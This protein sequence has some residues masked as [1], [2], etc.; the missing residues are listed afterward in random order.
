LTGRSLTDLVALTSTGRVLRVKFHTVSDKAK[1]TPLTALF[2]TSDPLLTTLA[3]DEYPADKSLVLLSAQGRIKK[4]PLAELANVTGRGLTVMRLAP[5]DALVAC[6][7]GRGSQLVLAACKGR[8]FRFANNET[9]IPPAGLTAGGVQVSQF[10]AGDAM[11]GLVAVDPG[12]EILL[13]TQAGQAKR[14]VINEIRLTERSGTIAGTPGFRFL[15]GDRLVGMVRYD[16][17]LRY[18]AL[19]SAERLV[20]LAAVAVE[21]RTGS[22]QAAVVLQADERVIGLLALDP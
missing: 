13:L 16:P 17:S 19:T 18:V 5:E 8:L 1:G 15:P 6:Q 22:G 7:E 2:N 12:Q 10:G 20:P 14:L 9:Q 11:L 3:F 21:S 4:V